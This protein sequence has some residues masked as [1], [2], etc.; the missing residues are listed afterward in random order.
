LGDPETRFPATADLMIYSHVPA[1]YCYSKGH[2]VS[3]SGSDL[4]AG[5]GVIM[6]SSFIGGLSAITLTELLLG[7]TLWLGFCSV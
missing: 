5:E 7:A 6:I 1:V 4:T 2:L 3:I